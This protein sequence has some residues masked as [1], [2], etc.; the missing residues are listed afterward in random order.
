MVKSNIQ[1]K[2]Y[3]TN[4]RSP[5]PQAT[6]TSVGEFLDLLNLI[7]HTSSRASKCVHPRGHSHARC[8]IKHS[9]RSILAIEISRNAFPE[10]SSSSEEEK[11][12][13]EEVSSGPRTP[14][15]S[16]IITGK[17]SYRIAPF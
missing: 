13:E 16:R 11:S 10:F 8:T 15:I 6:F 3:A 4:T 14:T 2:S 9:F 5:G 12:K 1:N 7:S 17:L